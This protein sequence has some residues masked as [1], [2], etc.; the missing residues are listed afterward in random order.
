VINGDNQRF[1]PYAEGLLFFAT[2]T[3]ELVLDGNNFNWTGTIF[4]RGAA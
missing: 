1:T 4:I 2:G 3:K